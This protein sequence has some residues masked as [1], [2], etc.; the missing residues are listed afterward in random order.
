M[1]FRA[2][3]FSVVVLCLP[4]SL[5]AVGYAA[6]VDTEHMFGFM[7]GSDVGDPGERE[8]QSKTTARLSKSGGTYQGISQALE[9]EFVPAKNFRVELGGT[10]AAY[11]INNVSGFSDTRRSD[12]QGG[13]AEFRYRFLDRETAPF[14]LTFGVELHADRLDENTAARV[15]AYGTEFVLAVDRELIPDRV[16]AAFNLLYQPE[17][18]SLAI[19]GAP[20]Q[21]EST[22]GAAAALMVQVV[23]GVFLGSEAR[24]LRQYDG[25]GLGDFSGDAVFIGPTAFVKLSERSRLT[26][27]WSFQVSGSS[28]EAAGHLN[29][30]DFERHQARLI[31]GVNF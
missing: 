22:I 3:I 17:W 23:P 16:V 8:V 31:F 7:I 14:G 27:A 25:I 26:A 4:G 19:P 1:A 28:T 2:R 11:N 12:F 21:R 15:R 5:P 29:L 18:T 13:S 24:Y 6:E 9:L 10:L 20:I 30:A